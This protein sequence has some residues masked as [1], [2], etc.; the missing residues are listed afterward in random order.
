[1]FKNREMSILR[2]EVPL[3]VGPDDFAPGKVDREKLRVLFNQLEFRTLLPRML[4]ALGEDDDAD[5]DEQPEGIGYEVDVRHL[6]DAD[7]VAKLLGSLAGTKDRVSL[8]GRWAG[9]A[10]RS[11]LL[12]LGGR[13][14]R[15]KS[16][17]YMSAEC[18]RP[19]GARRAARR[20]CG[21]TGRRWSRTGRRSSRTGSASSICSRSNPTPR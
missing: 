17:T 1:M 21:P 5:A 11:T 3:E 15:P 20:W 6:R 12:G 18:W 19:R 16:A 9:V 14:P 13:R 2:R 10:G 8:D 7:E 4:E